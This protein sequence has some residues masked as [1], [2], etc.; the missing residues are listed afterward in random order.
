LDNSIAV[1]RGFYKSQQGPAKRSAERPAA[2]CWHACHAE[3]VK[4]VCHDKKANGKRGQ[5]SVVDE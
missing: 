5:Q 3:E 4:R 1:A 2:R